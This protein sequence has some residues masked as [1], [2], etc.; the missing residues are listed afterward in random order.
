MDQI[1]A[2]VN[3]VKANGEMILAGLGG[4]YTF[5]LLVVHITPTPK[6]DEILGRV[7]DVVHK[8]AGLLKVKK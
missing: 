6:D 5:L 1:M 7:Y 4:L 8:A 2:V 3:F